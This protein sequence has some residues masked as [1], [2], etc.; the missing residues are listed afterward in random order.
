MISLALLQSG[1]T[2]AKRIYE[3]LGATLAARVGGRIGNAANDTELKV[4]QPWIK[5]RAAARPQYTSYVNVDIT[6][7][8][9]IEK[10]RSWG[11]VESELV[12]V[13]FSPVPVPVIQNLFSESHQGR[14]FVMFRN[15]VE[16]L[17]SKF[18]YLQ[19]ATWEVEYNPSWVD[20]GLVEWAQQHNVDNNFYVSVGLLL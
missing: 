14:A 17:I 15:P 18:Y 12:D 7:K 16:R 6:S 11:L 1:G 2:T 3:C 4:V 9:G 5:K 13:I 10:A 20:I 8:E 19:V